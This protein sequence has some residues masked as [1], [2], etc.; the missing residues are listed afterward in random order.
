MGEEGCGR[1]DGMAGDEGGGG[2]GLEVGKRWQRGT[3]ADGGMVGGRWRSGGGGGWVGMG[4]LSPSLKL[5]GLHRG[6]RGLEG[7]QVPAG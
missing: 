2:S 5:Y 3:L 4:C 1:E 6:S 7:V